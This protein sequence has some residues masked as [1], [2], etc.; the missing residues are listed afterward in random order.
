[1][2]S[3]ATEAS[4][5]RTQ[6]PGSNSVQVSL[7]G[8]YEAPVAFGPQMA[9]HKVVV[10]ECPPPRALPPPKLSLASHPQMQCAAAL[11]GEVHRQRVGTAQP[12]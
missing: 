9:A 3:W 11:L 1:M 10:P 12:H 8:S 4:P 5:L 7:F 2:W 6:I